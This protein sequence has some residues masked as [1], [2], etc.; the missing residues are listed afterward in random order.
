MNKGGRRRASAPVLPAPGSLVVRVVPDV[1]GLDKE[2]DYLVPDAPA[3]SVRE[4]SVVRVDLAGRRVGGW[5]V[6][7]G[8]EPPAGRPLLEVAKVTGWGPEPELLDLAGWAAWRWAGRRRSLLATAS[9]AGAV[10]L[11]PVR[12]LHRPAAPPVASLLADLPSD[13]PLLLRLPPASDVTT[14]VAE[15]AQRGPTLVVVPSHARASVLAARLRAA[16]GDVALMPGDWAQARAG[17][18]VVAGAR[19]AVWAPCPGLAG[20]VVVDGHDEN[21]AQEQ[22]PTWHAVTVAAERARRAG[23][24]CV[25][26]S[27]CPTLDLLRSGPLRVVSRSV[28]RAGWAALQVVD[29]RL[30]DP[31]LGLYSERLV[32][33]VRSERRVLCVL[34]RTGRARLLA[35]SA[36]GTVARCERCGAAVSQQPG[37]AAPRPLECP[38]C[39]LVRPQVCAACGSTSLKALRVGVTKVREE[40][41]DLARRAVGEVTASTA[42]TPDAPVLVGTEAVLHRAS[43]AGPPWAVAFLDFDQ[44]LL[45]PRVRAAEEALA[46]L[47]TASR[48]AG[49][50]AGR[51]VVQTRLPDHPVVRAALLA[52]PGRIVVGEEEVRRALRLPP[53]VSV[54][55][56][57][58]AGAAEYAGALGALPGSPVEVLG[59]A[60]G[61]WLV[62]AQ[63]SDALAGVLAA[64]PRP[65]GRLRVAVD[66]AL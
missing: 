63:S 33:L 66:P 48:L 26:T 49:G 18:A 53:F 21:L 15:M 12:A 24:P 42:E 52:D 14:V 10:P 54:A 25:V 55:L 39:S 6:A 16:G 3:A 41:E 32:A 47:A 2:F 20:I 22:A 1:A 50:R 37:A 8:V 19:A 35:C 38:K 30:D 34:N 59:P 40:L 23:V 43:R 29:R 28:E 31:R 36:C 62:K 11:L 61:E 17:A 4:G 51:V 5:V 58:G 9:P 64:V 65:P 13:R 46:L 44:E 57:S 7:V 60:G 45:A 27:P 56:L